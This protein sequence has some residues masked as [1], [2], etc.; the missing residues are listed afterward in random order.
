M[1]SETPPLFDYFFHIMFLRQMMKLNFG[2]NAVFSAYSYMEDVNDI[3][4]LNYDISNKYYMMT[5][6]YLLGKGVLARPPYV[7][8][9]KKAEFIE[10]KNYMSGLS[11]LS[12]KRSLNTVEV[13]YIYEAVEDNYFCNAVNYRIRTIC[14]FLPIPR[15]GILVC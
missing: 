7:N 4:K 14:S 5:T 12:E 6:K 2:Y 13:G 1:M 11:I 9:P 10:N 3:L 15:K 8:M